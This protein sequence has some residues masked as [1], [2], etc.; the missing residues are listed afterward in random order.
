MEEAEC[1]TGKDAEDAWETFSQD[2]GRAHPVSP[3]E[4]A[5]F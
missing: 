5:E 3:W 2:I 1:G 4:V